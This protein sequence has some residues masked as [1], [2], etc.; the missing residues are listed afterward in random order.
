MA[1]KYN[2]KPST[3]ETVEASDNQEFVRKWMSRIK[4]RE[5]ARKK[6]AER[7]HWKLNVD[8]F[9]GKWDISEESVDVDIPPLNLFFGYVK[10]EIPSLY[11]RDPKIK[12]NPRNA[13]SIP[14]AKLHELVLN[15]LWRVKKLK[16]ENKKTIWDALLASDGWIKVGYTGSFGTVE[17][18]NGNTLETIESEDFFAYRTPFD[19]VVFDGMAVDPPHDCSWMAFKV[20]R[21]LS[22]VQK[23]K[24]YKHIDE[25]ACVAL[26]DENKAK[27][28]DK[29]SYDSDVEMACLYEVWDKTNKEKFI[30]GVGVSKGPMQRGPWPYTKLKGFPASRLGFNPVNDEPYSVPDVFMGERQV[31]EKI[32]LRAIE[33]EAVKCQTRQFIA[34]K[35]VFDDEAKTAYKNSSAGQIVEINGS[36]TADIAPMPYANV[37]FDIWPLEDRIDNDL[38]NIWG[39]TA[40]ERG[41]AEKSSTRA[42]AEIKLRQA[43]SVNRR[44]EKVD[45]VEDF[46]EDVAS[47]LMALVSEFADTP[48]YVRL[49]GKPTEEVMSILQER[50][51]ASQPGAVTGDSGFTFTKEDID[52]EFDYEVV[53]GSTA[54]LDAQRKQE[55]QTLLMEQGPKLGFLPG[56]PFLTTVTLD[57]AEELDIPAYEAAM[58]EEVQMQKE[59]RQAQADKE[60]QM[61]EAS[62]RQEATDQ[63]LDAEKIRVKEDDS[64]RKA[65]V[66]LATAKDKEKEKETKENE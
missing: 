23:N 35:G 7:Y 56:G 3:E 63:Q 37:Q 13:K 47:K 34:K 59:I 18:G 52:G 12:V 20:Y 40:S 1:D 42:V 43:G 51:S 39:Q 16:K 48:Q 29:E 66:S 26:D 28:T 22:E 58:R 5:D 46:V 41:G 27:R 60:T 30:L 21:P 24:G 32:K 45:I 64:I 17:D 2:D 49:S 25:L 19:C 55:L 6:V 31:L 44:A 8:R 10:T 61:M 62:I 53:S 33:L 38:V 50:P 4:K 15:N 9:K 57:F 65:S 11:Q 36:P 14:R 54:P